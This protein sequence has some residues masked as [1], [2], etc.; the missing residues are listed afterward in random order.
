MM[1]QV[2]LDSHRFEEAERLVAWKAQSTIHRCCRSPSLTPFL[3][4]LFFD[5]VVA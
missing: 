1:A 5:P 2:D 4:S 3:S